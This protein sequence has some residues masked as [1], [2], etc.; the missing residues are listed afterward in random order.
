MAKRSFMDPLLGR[1]AGAHA[2]RQYGRFLRDAHAARRVQEKVLL[3]KIARNADSDY[4]RAH[5]F[6]KIKSYRD[7]V[8]QVPVQS[9]E[10]LRP[11][12]SKVM[13]GQTGAMFGKGQR[14][15]MFA[16]TSGSTDRPKYVPVTK[17]FLDE[18]RRGWNAFGVKAL[19]DHPGAFLRSILQVVS[20]MDES[21]TPL[22]IPCGSISGLLGAT[23]KRIVRRYYVTPRVTA[24]IEDSN[25][26]YYTIMRFAAPVDVGWLVTASPATQVKLARTADEHAARLIRDVR[27]GTIIAPGDIPPRVLQTLKANIRPDAATA[28]RL[29]ALLERNGSL[30]PRHYWHL[31]FLANWTGGTM[32]LH[33]QEFPKYFGDA[34]VRDIGLL[35]TEGR[36][37]VPLVDGTP[38]GVL[39]VGGSFFEFVSKGDADGDGRGTA[40]TVLRCHELAVGEEYRV[41]LTTSAGFYRYD[42]GDYVRVHRFEGQAPVIEFL[43]RGEH[44][45]SVTGEKLTEWQ[46]T[47]AFERSCQA[48][49]ASP[50]CFVLCPR[51]GDPPKYLLYVEERGD[52]SIDENLRD[53]ALLAE[54]LDRQLGEI[55]IE[56]ASKRSSRR[57]GAVEAAALKS[58]TLAQMDAERRNQ[59]GGGNEQF[60]HRYLLA[61]PGDDTELASSRVEAAS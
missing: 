2:K 54:A 22:G 7:F 8:G 47:A 56:Y 18:Y 21:R 60:K 32:G 10:D 19:L 59:R 16:M 4:G 12:V 49:G 58:G 41:L 1:L 36:V 31:S 5:G 6:S 40:A 30:L 53:H 29:D 24:Y 14:V 51:W 43:H 23:Q 28:A 44:T 15:L 11:Y 3:E 42:I 9:Y 26:R 48:L 25:A 17:A 57:L 46:V 50:E 52:R 34:P 35:A 37:S 33:L 13:D 39:D 45:A 55:N 20:P 38:G 61:S 27:D